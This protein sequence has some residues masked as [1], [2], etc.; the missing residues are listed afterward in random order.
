MKHVLIFK[1][2]LVATILL[3][4]GPV[5]ADSGIKSAVGDVLQR[6]DRLARDVARDEMRKPDQILGF[7][8]ITPSMHVLDVLAGGGYYTEIF[9]RYLNDGGHVL[10][11]NAPP[12]LGFAKDE[13]AERFADGRMGDIEQVIADIADMDFEPES[14]DAVFFGLGFHDTYY[15]SDYWPAVDRVKF[16]KTLYDALKPGGIFGVTD[17]RSAPG[18][19]PLQSG[20]LLHR[21]DP[22]VVIRDMEAAGFELVGESDV[23]SRDDDDYS[24][25]VFK[26]EVRGKTDRFALKFIKPKS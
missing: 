15:V 24:L 17:H 4:A 21:I 23:L 1:S 16:L 19:D 5:F 20:Q 10:M 12:Y 13:L 14:F 3:L 9:H 25:S 2:I 26:P 6:E 18:A 22:Q 11:Y 8:G 7:L